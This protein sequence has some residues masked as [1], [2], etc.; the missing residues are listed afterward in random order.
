MN[1]ETK[2]LLLSLIDVALFLVRK[3]TT[4]D[5]SLLVGEH[6]LE[7]GSARLDRAALRVTLILS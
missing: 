7:A 4:G 3:N 5:N 6:P 1:K 2:G